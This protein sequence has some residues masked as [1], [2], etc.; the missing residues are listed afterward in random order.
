M[1][2]SPVSRLQPF[3]PHGAASDV[4]HSARASPC[5]WSGKPM[6]SLGAS[7]LCVAGNDGARR[8][9]FFNEVVTVIGVDACAS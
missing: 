6:R 7:K 8:I 2:A 5:A 3:L 4:V 9:R 1:N